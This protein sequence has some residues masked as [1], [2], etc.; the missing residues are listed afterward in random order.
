LAA[1]PG[2]QLAFAGGATSG[3]FVVSVARN[4]SGV[5]YYFFLCD[6]SPT[7]DDQVPRIVSNVRRFLST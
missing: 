7:A 5:N 2:A 4:Q 6:V 1:I 3:T